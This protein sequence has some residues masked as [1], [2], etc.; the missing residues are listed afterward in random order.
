MNATYVVR[1]FSVVDPVSYLSGRVE[2]E[3]YITRYRPEYPVMK[4]ANVNLDSDDKILG[5]YLGNR[6]Y[7]CDRDIVFGENLL[8]R[9]VILSSSSEELFH[10]L[11]QY[12]FT[13]VMVHLELMKDWLWTLKERERMLFIEFYNRFF[14]VLDKNKPYALFLLKNPEDGNASNEAT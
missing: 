7:Y 6:R 10:I 1:Q 3:D 12:G 9:S 4:Y 8:T 11:R 14:H 13:H 5:L 2:R